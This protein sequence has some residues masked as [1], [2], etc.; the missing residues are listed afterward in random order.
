L[1]VRSAAART[2]ELYWVPEWSMEPK[3]DDRTFITHYE[4]R[5]DTSKEPVNYRPQDVSHFRYG[6][7]D[8]RNIRKAESPLRSLFREIF[9]DDEAANYT[10]SM[11]RN[12]G[13]PPVVL[14]PTDPS[15]TPSREELE[16]TKQRYQEVTTGDNRGQVLVMYGPTK[17]DKLGYNPSEMNVRELRRIPEERVPAVLGLNAM[18]LG[19]GAGL[20]RSTYSNYEQAYRAAYYGNIIPTQRLIAS[21]LESQLL[22]DFGDVRQLQIDFDLS[23]VQQLQED[24]DA[25]HARAREDLKAGLLSLNEAREVIGRKPVPGEDGDVFYIPTTLTPTNPDQLV[26][27]VQPVPPAL[28]ALPPGQQEALPPGQQQDGQPA[29]AKMVQLR[30]RKMVGQPLMLTEEELAVLAIVT[31]GDLERA[32]QLWQEEAPEPFADLLDASGGQL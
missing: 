10:A 24:E 32:R 13:V 4:Y 12:V 18:V 8:P 14:S 17:V 5:P 22:P 29:P 27:E 16:Q 21:E 26:P 31:A 20:D 25:K 7:P 23:K 1:K 11:L 2:V 15:M 9:T 19:L 30:H 6:R 28:Q 3:G